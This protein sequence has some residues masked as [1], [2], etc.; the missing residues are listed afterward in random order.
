MKALLLILAIAAPAGASPQAADVQTSG[1]FITGIVSDANGAVQGVRVTVDGHLA[2]RTELTDHDGSFRIEMVGD[3]PLPAEVYVRFQSRGHEPY[4]KVAMPSAAPRP[5]RIELPR[6]A[7]APAR[8]A[9]CLPDTVS[10]AQ[11]AARL[12]MMAEGVAVR[13][14]EAILPPCLR[15][16][17]PEVNIEALKLLPLVPDGKL[18][19]FEG[20]A[21]A[22]LNRSS[23]DLR[24]AALDALPVATVAGRERSR[25]VLTL[26]IADPNRLVRCGAARVLMAAV[27]QT[28]DDTARVAAECVCV[29][30]ELAVR[31][32]L[33]ALKAGGSRAKAAVPTLL[34]CAHLDRPDLASPG[35]DSGPIWEQRVRALRGL[36]A[37]GAAALPAVTEWFVSLVCPEPRFPLLV[38][39][40]ALQLTAEWNVHDA[41]IRQ[42]LARAWATCGDSLIARDA[43][44]DR[45]E[46]GA[47]VLQR[48]QPLDENLARDIAGRMLQAAA[49]RFAWTSV[50]RGDLTGRSSWTRLVPA[51]YAATPEAVRAELR[52]PRAESFDTFLAT[53]LL[54]ADI[55]DEEAVAL[56]RRQLGPGIAAPIRRRAVLG[57]YAADEKS[58]P[59]AADLAALTTQLGRNA[60]E[61]ED[62]LIVFKTLGRLGPRAADH[63][64]PAIAAA[65]RRPWPTPSATDLNWYDSWWLREGTT[66]QDEAA[67]ALRRLGE[68]GVRV[69]PEL[70]EWGCS[71][72]PGE[73]TTFVRAIRGLGPAALPHFREL[74]EAPQADLARLTC[75]CMV[76]AT[77]VEPSAILVRPLARQLT[78]EQPQV[79]VHAL[80]ALGRIG[81]DALAA[82][83]EIR[84]FV[85]HRD[86]TVAAAAQSALRKIEGPRV[87]VR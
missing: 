32:G 73:R 28:T 13:Q 34:A 42:P 15:E 38:P 43:V 37:I 39:A 9:R 70:L 2:T 56:L 80:T 8:L 31:D 27:G 12:R 62:A 49:S 64:L 55:E 61:A 66:V 26:A 36:R 45:R 11:K 87:P 16:P 77:W 19:N 23:V 40:L 25:R 74:L 84:R 51:I 69:L 48:L 75:V 18:A 1:R 10:G 22:L 86:D 24:R 7:R 65:L 79:T 29:A 6:L 58:L 71:L 59:L 47:Q 50:W 14:L 57:A 44:S 68:A 54:A 3:I 35:G 83:P 21:T 52:Q 30:D 76:L 20:V 63:A 67:L 60:E 53:L 17:D 82:A 41:D 78:S 5:M 81:P 46:I 4:V 85:N 33:E 72:R